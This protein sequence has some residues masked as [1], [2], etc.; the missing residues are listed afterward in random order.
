MRGPR[1]EAVTF[2]VHTAHSAVLDH[3]AADVWCLPGTR[4]SPIIAAA[5]RH[6]KAAL[7]T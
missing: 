1:D 2:N 4:V 7:N 5:L 3:P 6:A